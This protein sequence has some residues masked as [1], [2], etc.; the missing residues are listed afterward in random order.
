MKDF[1][2]ADIGEGL[3]EGTVGEVFVK[4]GDKV[5]EFDPLFSVE[6]DKVTEE[7]TSIDA[8]IVGEVLIKPGQVIKVGETVVRIKTGDSASSAP[9]KKAV[10]K[11]EEKAEEGSS[12]I[13][14]VPVSNDLIAS[15][16]TTSTSNVQNNKAILATPLVRKMAKD[17]NIN[18][19]NIQGT[20]PNGRIK[21]SDLNNVKSSQGGFTNSVQM[22]TNLKATGQTKAEKMT[23]I[24]RA[25]SKKMSQ[26]KSII[27]EATLMK[28]INVTKLM[29]IRSQLK[30]QAE[31]MG[32]KLT[33]MPFF[34]KAAQLA[35]QKFP[36]LNTSL[37]DATEEILWKDYF[38]IGMATDTPKGLMVPV[39]KG[40]DQLNIM[41]LANKVNELALKT[42]DGKV[43]GD[44]M[45]D[46]TFTISNFG[47]AGIE[48]ATPVINHPE[49]A[50]L[51]VGLIKKQPI[52]NKDGDIEVASILRVSLTIDHRV[53]DG[54]DGGR[55]LMEFTNLLEN[56]AI[57][58][59]S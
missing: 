7:I 56:P 15:R 29:E 19:A 35:L 3:T 41:Q 57:L 13:G 16:T 8:G 47:S 27:P 37:N 38:N 36:V 1:K 43:K 24:R 52:V 14:A 34:I 49:T 23:P 2:F 31:S 20:G 5:D 25:I 9:A 48:F 58:L 10:A 4:V 50:I 11:K 46:G 51:G 33:F 12:V 18:L 17:L 22:P 53:I 30:A 54:A 55:F 59:V 45:K 32:T 21:K 42:R 6:T 39:V 40:V 26:A 44:E 28:E